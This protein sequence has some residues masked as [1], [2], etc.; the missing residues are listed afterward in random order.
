MGKRV[1]V[2]MV[3]TKGKGN[4]PVYMFADNGENSLLTLLTQITSA[5]AEL[6]MPKDSDLPDKVFTL[7]IQPS[8][9]HEPAPFQNSRFQVEADVESVDENYSIDHKRIELSFSSLSPDSKEYVDRVM[10]WLNA[11]EERYLRCEIIPHQT[12]AAH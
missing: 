7:S 6:L 10:E 5:G 1:E 2:F 9:H 12:S 4:L 8:V 3:Q 11:D